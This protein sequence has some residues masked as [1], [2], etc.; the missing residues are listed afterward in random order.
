M[1]LAWNENPRLLEPWGGGNISRFNL[2]VT[3]IELKHIHS[4]PVDPSLRGEYEEGL[5]EGS[6]MIERS[7]PQTWKKLAYDSLWGRPAGGFLTFFLLSI[8]AD[9]PS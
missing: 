2:R 3:S 4:L 9:D 8:Q 1:Y 5:V 7:S 6:P